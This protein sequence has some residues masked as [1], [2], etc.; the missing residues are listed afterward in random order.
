M[1]EYM[2][3]I[4]LSVRL[5]WSSPQFEKVNSLSLSSHI[6][7]LTVCGALKFRVHLGPLA[8]S[9][10]DKHQEEVDGPFANDIF[11]TKI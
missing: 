6:D 10:E 7:E 3:K 2:G 9:R 11:V 8:R 1:D 4:S 5:L